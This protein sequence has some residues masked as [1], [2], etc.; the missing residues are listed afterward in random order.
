MS[1]PALSLTVSVQSPLEVL[2][3]EGR[4]QRAAG[5]VAAHQVTGRWSAQLVAGTLFSNASN[6]AS[7]STVLSIL[8]P[9]QPNPVP[10]RPPGR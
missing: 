2:A 4:Q 8:S 6:A 1:P 9:E 7:S 5:R 3:V 10:V